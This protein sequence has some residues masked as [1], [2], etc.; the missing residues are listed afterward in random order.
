MKQTRV[1]I[2][3]KGIFE[4][5]KLEKDVVGRNAYQVS[6]K[7]KLGFHTFLNGEDFIFRFCYLRTQR[8]THYIQASMKVHNR[9]EC[10]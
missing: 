5:I 8:H 7:W 3:Q 1:Y 6:K 4:M 10:K 9:G 2:E